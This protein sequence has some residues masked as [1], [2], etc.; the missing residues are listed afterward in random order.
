MKQNRE[1]TKCHKDD[2]GSK[3]SLPLHVTYNPIL[4]FKWEHGQCCAEH[5]GDIEGQQNMP[6]QNMPLQDV[7]D[8]ELIIFKKQQT[9]DKFWKEHQFTLQGARISP[10]LYSEEKDDCKS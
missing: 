6:P 1:N 8:F 5:K 7:D 10:S 4:W 9:Q 3:I 2:R